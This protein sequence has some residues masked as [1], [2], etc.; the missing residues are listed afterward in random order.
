MSTESTR[1]TMNGTDTMRF[2]MADQPRRTRDARGFVAPTD[3]PVIG[4]PAVCYHGEAGIV[5]RV[6]VYSRDVEMSVDESHGDVYGST[7]CYTTN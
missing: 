2:V 6:Y 4:S 3:R 5:T 1:V 7:I